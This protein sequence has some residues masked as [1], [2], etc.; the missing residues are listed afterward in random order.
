MGKGKK[1]K[2]PPMYVNSNVWKVLLEIED[3]RVKERKLIRKL[4]RDLR[5]DTTRRI[6]TMVFE[7]ALQSNSAFPSMNE[8]E[9]EKWITENISAVFIALIEQGDIVVE[10]EEPSKWRE[11]GV[12]IYDKIRKT[13]SKVETDKIEVKEND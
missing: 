5:E 7:Q 13:V 12:A 11:A 1:E 8:K 3:L 2:I 10:E 4:W 9:L 6:H